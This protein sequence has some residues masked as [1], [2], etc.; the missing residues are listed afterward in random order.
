MDD[1][2]NDSSKYID[3]HKRT[4]ILNDTYLMAHT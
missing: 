3:M 4:H 2:H 1:K